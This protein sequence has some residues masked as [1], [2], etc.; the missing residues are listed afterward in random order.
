MTKDKL[1]ELQD[2]VDAA[3]AAVA[4]TY[5]TIDSINFYEEAKKRYEEAL[6]EFKEINIGQ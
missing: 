4:H 5:G 3:R 2:K 6:K 1:T